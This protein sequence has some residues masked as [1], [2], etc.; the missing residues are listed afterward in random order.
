MTDISTFYQNM[1]GCF[2][3]EEMYKTLTNT[4]GVTVTMA[5]FF[6]LYLLFLLLDSLPPVVEI[7]LLKS[8]N[9]L[10]LKVYMHIIYVNFLD[11]DKLVERMLQ[12]N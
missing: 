7:A 3:W 5:F 1:G 8:P 12:W 6:L 2:D 4:I 11:T 9:R 10:F